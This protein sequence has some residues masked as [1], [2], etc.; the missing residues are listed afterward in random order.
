MEAGWSGD[1]GTEEEAL[2]EGGNGWIGEIDEV[3]RVAEKVIDTTEEE[4]EGGRWG[5]GGGKE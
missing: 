3:Q 5:E 1:G 4:G 2:N